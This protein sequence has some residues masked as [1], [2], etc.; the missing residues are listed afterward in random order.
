MESNFHKTN[1]ATEEEEE[2]EDFSMRDRIRQIVREEE[3]QQK[4]WEKNRSKSKGKQP[5]LRLDFKQP[6]V[7]YIFL[8]C[9]WLF[10]LQA[11][12]KR[13][14]LFLILNLLLFLL[15]WDRVYNRFQAWW[16]VLASLIV[17]VLTY[18]AM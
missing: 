14:A 16:V 9:H 1:D 6:V 11:W 13:S 2:E 18:A 8:C 12:E 15:Q 17:L 7:W 10:S 4:H 5:V 3:Q